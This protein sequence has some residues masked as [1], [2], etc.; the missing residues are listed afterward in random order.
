MPNFDVAPPLDKLTGTP[1]SLIL[2]S[3][4]FKTMGNKITF[5]SFYGGDSPNRHPVLRHVDVVQPCSNSKQRCF[6]LV[7]GVRY[8]TI[9]LLGHNSLSYWSTLNA[10]TR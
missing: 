5:V 4:L 3:E 1:V 8:C 9:A 10:F 6:F 7:G 2:F